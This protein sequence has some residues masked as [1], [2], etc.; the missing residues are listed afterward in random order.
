[1]NK[2]RSF[3]WISAIA[4][5][6]ALTSPQQG[7]G[8]IRY[9]VVD[10]GTLGS[11]PSE[12]FG[13]S[14][15]GVAVG[16]SSLGVT[17]PSLHPFRWDGQIADLGAYAS[18]PHAVA[19]AI[20]DADQAVGSSFALGALDSHGVKWEGGDV[21]LLGHFAPR[22]VNGLCVVV[23]AQRY[24][25]G[26]EWLEGAVHWQDGVLTLLG[27]LGGR[28]S[29]AM[30][31]NEAG[32]AVGTSTLADDVTTRAFWW[33][34]A[35]MTDLG[36]LG[37]DMSQANDVNDFR[38]VVG[39]AQRGDGV[40]H[41][42]LFQVDDGGQV[43]QRLDLG[44]LGGSNSYA[45]AINNRA[46]VVGTSDGRPFLWESGAMSDLNEF[47]DPASGWELTH[48]RAINDAGQIVGRGK[49]AGEIRAFML[50]PIGSVDCAAIARLSARCNLGKLTVKAKTSLAAG[51]TLTIDVNGDRQTMTINDRGIGKVKFKNRTGIQ[52]ASV[53]ECPEHTATAD[54]G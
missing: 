26:G 34:G 43:T 14:G 42:F 39:F 24:P 3:R 27:T 52:N 47:I 6:M 36:T 29:A 15:N 51:T 12:A 44:E 40:N 17:A 18:D 31:I 32:Q 13:V 4:A 11:P 45:F 25:S 38:Q 16:Q 5:A 9:E 8:E 35:A 48:A 30:A 50:R 19:F 41:A 53:V 20:N 49:I 28:H 54:C 10:L 46:Q 2:R 37:G 1:M 23:G 22:D 33:D 7:F 21:Q